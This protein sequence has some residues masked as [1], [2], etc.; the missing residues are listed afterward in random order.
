MIELQS[1]E[2]D[3]TTN[4]RQIF[5]RLRDPLQAKWRKSA[6]LYRE[7]T[8]GKEPALKELSEFI[9][10]ESQTENDVVYGRSS[11]PTARVGR[12]N[13][14]KK[15][16]FMLKPASGAPIAT[17]TTEVAVADASINQGTGEVL[18]AEDDPV[19]GSGPSRGEVCKV[20][21]G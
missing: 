21:R 4:M 1:N 5:Y 16:P 19:V 12:G 8:G 9:T 18:P 11:T 10:G 14:S 2:L 15:Q 3:C 17:M 7:R 20:C 13:R 6:K